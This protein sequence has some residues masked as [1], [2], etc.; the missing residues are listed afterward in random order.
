[1]VSPARRLA[2]AHRTKTQTF[3]EAEDVAAASNSVIASPW[4]N[5]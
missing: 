4:H 2:R 1:M 3:A 5:G